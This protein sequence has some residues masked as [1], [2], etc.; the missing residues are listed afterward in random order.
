MKP[1]HWVVVHRP[2][3]RWQP[4]LSM[5]EQPGLQA[6][7][8]HYRGALA[9]GRLAWGGP[10]VDGRGGGMM[11]AQPQVTP[12]ELRDFAAADPCV[13]EGLLEFE[14]RPWMIA[15]QANG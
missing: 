11:V 12:E 5:F 3:P 4:G 10:F 1:T 7:V 13:R 8:E 2:G 6:H 15:M 14:L 9:S